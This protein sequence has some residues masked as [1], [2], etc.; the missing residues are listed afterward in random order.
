[1]RS[2]LHQVLHNLGRN[3]VVPTMTSPAGK[4]T[5]TIPS[6]LRSRESSLWI[7]TDS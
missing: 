7:A 2:V 3:M 6:S 5:L 1:M 4:P